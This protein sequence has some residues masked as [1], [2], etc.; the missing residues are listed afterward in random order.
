[1]RNYPVGV[2]A[3]GWDHQ[4]GPLLHAHTLAPASRY[5]RNVRA[6]CGRSILP[7]PYVRATGPFDPH[8]TRACTDCAKRLRVLRLA[9]TGTKTIDQA[10]DE[11][12]R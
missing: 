11:V 10:E 1:M 2:T 4:D 5:G 8:H 7:N 12:R 9:D 6:L 3:R